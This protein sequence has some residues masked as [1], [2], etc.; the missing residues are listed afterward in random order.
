ML[1]GALRK[2]AKVGPSKGLK[3]ITAKERSKSAKQL[4]TLTQLLTTPLGKYIKGFPDSARLHPFERALLDLTVGEERYERTLERVNALRKSSLE[5]GKGFAAAANKATSR[6]MATEVREE[7][8][9]TLE[10]HYRKGLPVLEDLKQVAIKLRKLPVAELHT[11][12]VALVGAPNVG[13]SSLVNLLSSGKPE[14]NN[15]PFTTRGIKMGHVMVGGTRH[16]LTD[17][18]GVLCRSEGKRNKMEL[19]TIAA[20]EHLP[21]AVLFVLDLTGESG[22]RVRDQ[23]AIRAELKERFSERPW[24]DVIS[25]AD[26]LPSDADGFAARAAEVREAGL[27]EAEVSDADAS[28]E[29]VSGALPLPASAASASAGECC[30]VSSLESTGLEELR[31][32]ITGTLEDMR[33]DLPEEE[34]ELPQDWDPMLDRVSSQRYGKI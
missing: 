22:T 7:A 9:A 29:L 31:D 19:L 1:E 6:K 10:E 21:V 12:M 25:K 30:F 33:P 16:I 5:M 15:Y 2:A 4:D 14:V 20:L 17:T 11:P 13:K 28:A 8:Y 24:I 18:P 26:L 32:R 23:I 3:N 34:E 27:T